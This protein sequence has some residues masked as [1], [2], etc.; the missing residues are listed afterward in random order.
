MRKQ[1][2]SST[3][4]PCCVWGKMNDSKDAATRWEGQVEEFKMSPFY[5]E[6]LGIDGEPLEF[7]WIILSGFSSLQILQQIQNDLRERNIKLEKFADR[8]IFM[9]M[10]NDIDWTRER[11]RR[12]LYFEFRKVK[13]YAKKFSQGHWTFLGPGVEK[14]WH[15]KRKYLPEVEESA[16]P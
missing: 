5:K 3:P 12:D 8:L 1:K 7:E 2:Y 6:L 14:K 15:G 13:M 9:S 16:I 4:I 11:K 10:F